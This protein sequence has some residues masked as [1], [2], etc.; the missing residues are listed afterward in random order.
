MGVYK[1]K[2]RTVIRVVTRHIY[3]YVCMYICICFCVYVCIY[4]LVQ[5]LSVLWELL[6][7]LWVCLLPFFFCV[8]CS[9]RG[10]NSPS[11]LSSS[12]SLYVDLGESGIE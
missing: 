1:S 9:N 6:F 10:G 3:V 12:S 11:L 2:L 5:S 4:V 7:L 8:K